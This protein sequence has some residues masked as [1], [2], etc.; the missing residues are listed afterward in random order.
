M[1][2]ARGLRV[3]RSLPP[4]VTPQ[5]LQPAFEREVVAHQAFQTLLLPDR[6][7][8]YRA[9]HGKSAKQAERDCIMQICGMQPVAAQP[10]A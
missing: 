2:D 1:A 8:L 10:P 7:I 5:S 4:V 3:L 9:R 6:A